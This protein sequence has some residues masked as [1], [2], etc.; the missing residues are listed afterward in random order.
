MAIWKVEAQGDVVYVDAAGLAAAKERVREVI[1][2]IPH[3]LLT[4]TEVEELPE[5]EV[6]L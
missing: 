5:D 3:H 2:S 4:F 1:G 6:F